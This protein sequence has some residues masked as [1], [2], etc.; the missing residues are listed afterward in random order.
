MASPFLGLRSASFISLQPFLSFCY[1][2]IKHSLL[3]SPCSLPS[4]AREICLTMGGSA[5]AFKLSLQHII[6][7]TEDGGEEIREKRRTGEKR[8]GRARREGV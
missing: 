3:P 4:L 6:I 2:P 7:I 5:Q 1:R 8:G